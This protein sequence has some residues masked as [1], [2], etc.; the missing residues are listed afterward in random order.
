M[1][2]AA[3]MRMIATTINNSMR[4]KPFC[5]LIKSPLRGVESTPRDAQDGEPLAK[6][7]YESAANHYNIHARLWA[8]QILDGRWWPGMDIGA[9]CMGVSFWRVHD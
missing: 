9:C 5:A 4:E 2:M 6:A 8:R 1:A 7:N 3:M